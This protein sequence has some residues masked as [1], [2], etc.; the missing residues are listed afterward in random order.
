MPENDF[1]KQVQDL[2]DGL[3]LK[4][5]DNVWH[6]VNERIK[7]DKKRR[8]AI[9]WLPLLLL[10][11]G[12]AGAYMIWGS[13]ADES[14]AKKMTALKETEKALI[15][16]SNNAAHTEKN[17]IALT[18]VDV[19]EKQNIT[20]AE[21]TNT[22]NK[23]GLGSGSQPVSSAITSEQVTP[24]ATDKY[25]VKRKPG[26]STSLPAF[27]VA[28]DNIKT[29]EQAIDHTLNNTKEQQQGYK[30][31]SKNIN[32]DNN[33]VK[34]V[35]GTAVQQYIQAQPFILSWPGN[36][37][38]ISASLQ[39][40]AAGT[41][42]NSTVRLAKKK[43]WEFGINAGAGFSNTGSG[44]SDI[45]NKLSFE[46]SAL[47]DYATSAPVNNMNAGF[48]A[49]QNN[50]YLAALPTSATPVKRGLMWNAGVSAKWYVKPRLALTGNFQYSYFSTSRE[51]GKFLSNNNGAF[52]GINSSARYSGYYS[53]NNAV[54]Y[55]NEYHLLELPLGIQWQLNKGTKL[56]PL[57]LNSGLSAGWLINSNALHYDKPTGI[58]YQDESLFNKFQIGLYAGLSAKLFQHSRMPLYV[59]PYMQYGL[60]NLVKSS[61]GT[62]QN[63]MSVGIKTEWI[64]WKK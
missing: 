52:A 4:P 54:N 55:K 24:Q 51:V 2:F 29:E 46:K 5:S 19:A 9:F 20:P 62:Q 50:V 42:S 63:L 13:G 45:F 11:L 22:D 18:D 61:S 6:N 31:L 64:L 60:S 16:N 25:P 56:F 57:Q 38:Q 15:E 44:L 28:E 26:K 41:A 8:R 23:D 10:L 30:D 12:G 7:K 32:E 39:K 47:T 21:I 35:N 53:G 3:K 48:V 17:T 36:E 27:S 34:D 1:E 49:S 33:A 43:S 59:G 14:I 37:K 58:Y 40:S